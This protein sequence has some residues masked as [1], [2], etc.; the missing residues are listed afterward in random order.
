[1]TWKIG[2]YSE[3]V[4]KVI[5]RLEKSIR[6]KYLAI[7]K[8]MLEEGPNLGMPYTKAMGNGLFEIRAKGQAGIARGFFCTIKNNTIMVLHVFVKKTQAT[9]HKELEIAKKRMKEVKKHEI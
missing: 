1:M 9:P 5:E 2:Y 4:I 3:S 8:A 6:T 7:I